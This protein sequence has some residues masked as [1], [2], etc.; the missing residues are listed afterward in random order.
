MGRFLTAL[1]TAHERRAALEPAHTRS[2]LL[3]EPEI[4]PLA[5]FQAESDPISATNQLTPNGPAAEAYQ[6]LAANLLR[7][8][9]TSGHHIVTLVGARPGVGTS[10]TALQLALWLAETTSGR[11]LL[12]DASG[13]VGT[14]FER[15]SLPRPN[16][17]LP[18]D[19]KSAR[20]R[21]SDARLDLLL[22]GPT[23]LGS[24]GDASAARRLF[25]DLRREYA[26]TIIDAGSGDDAFSESLAVLADAT[27]LVAQPVDATSAVLTVRRLVR[28]GA[29]IAGCA[30]I[31]ALSSGD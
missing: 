7:Q 8:L 17:P 13:P 22:L 1:R 31:D 24:Q 12:I 15:L 20:T 18:V 23:S 30:L 29:R 25:G 26:W 6:A 16:A 5:L 2:P 3:S 10:S 11:A 27:C 14:I 28:A 9:P 21:V 4:P 19:W